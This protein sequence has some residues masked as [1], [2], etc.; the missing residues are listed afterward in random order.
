LSLSLA[1]DT[2][3]NAKHF[4]LRGR[5]IDLWLYRNRTSEKLLRQLPL[6]HSNDKPCHLVSRGSYLALTFVFYT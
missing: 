5:N 6:L 2:H 4:F 3:M 1:S